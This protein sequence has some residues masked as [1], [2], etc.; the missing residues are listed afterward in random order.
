[1]KVAIVYALSIG[2]DLPP[3]VGAA[4]YGVL[5]RQIPRLAVS[6]LNGEGDRGI[7]FFPLIGPLEGRRQF[8]SVSHMLSPEKLVALLR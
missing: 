1:M 5:A 2:E 8:F 6:L 7:R 3:V 4:S